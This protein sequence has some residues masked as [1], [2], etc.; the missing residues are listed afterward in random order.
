MPK[1]PPP[2][3]PLV[4]RTMKKVR[5][6]DTGPEMAVRRL[7]SAHGLR[8][9]VNY[10]PKSPQLGRSTIDI[11]FPGKQ[12]AVF[13]DGCFWHNCPEHGEIPKANN[14]WWQKKF[15]ENTERDERVTNTLKEGGWQVQRFWSHEVPEDVCQF[16]REA[17][18]DTSELI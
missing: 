10:K 15:K 12:I 17:I 14:K 11:A 16:I 7:L 1:R 5:T 2:S 6:R 13:I 3:S 9:R 4:S 18:D 8:Y